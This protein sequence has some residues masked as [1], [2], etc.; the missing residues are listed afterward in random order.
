[1]LDNLPATQET[2]DREDRERAKAAFKRATV[3]YSA[4]ALNT[5]LCVMSSPKAKE[6]DQLR[7]AEF[8]LQSA[9]GA[10]SHT[11][12][13]RVAR[14]ALAEIVILA[15]EGAKGRRLGTDF[16]RNGEDRSLPVVEAEAGPDGIL[17]GSGVHAGPG[18]GD[19]ADLDTEVSSG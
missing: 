19:R 2:L 13:E 3:R 14:D 7:S 12:D 10:I 4:D 17:A 16:D 9:F 1:M 15:L 18:G 8:I 6:A 11:A 5:I